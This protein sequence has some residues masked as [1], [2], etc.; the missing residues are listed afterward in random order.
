[1][2]NKKITKHKAKEN[3]IES[4]KKKE[5]QR[6]VGTSWLQISSSEDEQKPAWTENKFLLMFKF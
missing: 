2:T 6:E 4:L 3:K 1:M 5:R